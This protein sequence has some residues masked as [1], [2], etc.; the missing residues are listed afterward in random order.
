LEPRPLAR[1]WSDG[2]LH[3]PGELGAFL[4][5]ESARKPAAKAILARTVCV[6]I[7]EAG[8]SP[9]V[10]AELRARIAELE[11]ENAALSATVQA[12]L[13][14]YD[15]LMRWRNPSGG[16]SDRDLLLVMR[17]A[18]D[19]TELAASAAGPLS[20]TPHSGKVLAFRKPA[21]RRTDKS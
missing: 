8:M 15:F 10:V 11:V 19:R 2:G 3:A 13:E 14:F 4:L 16:I 20:E 12:R 17:E 6:A 9:E 5:Q 18:L 21:T 1:V 7:E